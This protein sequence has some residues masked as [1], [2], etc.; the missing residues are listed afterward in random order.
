MVLLFI[1][2]SDYWRQYLVANDLQFVQEIGIKNEAVFGQDSITDGAET[3]YTLGDQQRSFGNFPE[4][5]T[6]TI[7]SY[8]GV[9]FDPVSFNVASTVVT[10]N[11]AS[12]FTHGLGLFRNLCRTES[13]GGLED[14]G[15]VDDGSN[16]YTI[17]PIDDGELI[18]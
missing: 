14:G 7:K 17:T 5:E 2:Y 13:S 10:G 18:S 15:V 1:T 9:S 12:V 6:E 11:I 4:L 3:F 8:T 16:E